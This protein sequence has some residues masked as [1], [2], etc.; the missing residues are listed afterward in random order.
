MAEESTI[1]QQVE[2]GKVDTAATLALKTYGA[3]VLGF[4]VQ[5]A[6]QETLA[7]DAFSI[8]AENVWR[9]LESFRWESS[10]RTWCYVLARRSLSRAA[11]GQ[12]RGKV[13]LS[14]NAFQ[15]IADSISSASMPL[16]RQQ[17]RDQLARLREELSE[18]ERMLL[19]LRVDKEM[20]WRDLAE[21]MGVVE[22]DTSPDDA[23]RALAGLRKRF[24]R[25]AARLRAMAE[26]SGLV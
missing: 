7:L 11:R 10:L 8:F 17:R 24:E 20:S 23:R 12:A 18:E 13:A 6:S 19:T 3:E 21:V 26:Q 9:S 4:L 5:C 22:P 25:M 15:Q 14:T 16:F 2:A 1:R